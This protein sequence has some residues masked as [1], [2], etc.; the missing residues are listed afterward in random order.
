M[1]QLYIS[2]LANGNNRAVII[3]GDVVQAAASARKPG[4]GSTLRIR[5]RK[6]GSTLWLDMVVMPEGAP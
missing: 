5:S 4:T 2:D 1:R 6:E 3:A